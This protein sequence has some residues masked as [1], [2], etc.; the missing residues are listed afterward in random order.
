MRNRPQRSPE[1]WLEESLRLFALLR[2]EEGLAALEQVLRLNPNNAL[3]YT[4][5]G[6]ALVDLRQDQEAL[7]A[8]EQALRLDPNYAYAYYNK[9]NTLERLGRKR[10][11][12]RAHERARQLGYKG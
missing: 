11:A 2:Y 5:K 7:K 4:L 12:Q 8:Y 10:E 9:G 3:A 6:T 1:Q